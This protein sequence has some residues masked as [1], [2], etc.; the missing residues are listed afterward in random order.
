MV[1]IAFDPQPHEAYNSLEKSATG[2]HLLDAIDE[3]LDLLE[4]DPGDSRV[5][6]R[7]FK[8]GLWGIPLRDRTEDWLII[9][10]CDTSEPDVIVIRYLGADPFA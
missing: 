6:R 1:E 5:R 3:A 7:S 10:E 9:W 8:D 4:A 2:A